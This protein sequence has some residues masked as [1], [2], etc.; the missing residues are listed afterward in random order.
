ME[1]SGGAR[2]RIREGD[3][4]MVTSASHPI[5]V[6]VDGSRGSTRAIEYAVQTAASQ[7]RA[8]CLVHVIPDYVPLTPMMPLTP[9]D[10][11]QTGEEILRAAEATARELDPG[12]V[13]TSELLSGPRVA[14]LVHLAEG[15]SLIVVGH[16]HR[17]VIDRILTGATATGVA[18]QA[19]CSVVSVPDGWEPGVRHDCVVVGFKAPQHSNELLAQAFAAADARKARLVILHAWKLP[20]AYDDILESGVAVQQWHDHAVGVIEPLLTEWRATYPDV[21]VEVR[22][23]HDQP[24]QALV[25]AAAEADLL[26]MVRRTHGFPAFIHLGAVA[27]AV[28]REATCPVEVV[29]PETVAVELPDLVLEESGTLQK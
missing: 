18:A 14:G 29:P 2:E 12:V 28:L 4:T 10:L 25:R 17:S 6:G 26:V 21:D 22:I 5:I 16:E 1:V 8:V 19:T 23:E 13:L 7:G 11:R 15:D 24:A 9:N 27:R 20:P 3:T